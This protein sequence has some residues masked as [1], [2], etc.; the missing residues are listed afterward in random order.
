MSITRDELPSG[1]WRK[2]KSKKQWGFPKA[3]EGAGWGREKMASSIK[4]NDT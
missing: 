3:L 2:K 4:L 1:F